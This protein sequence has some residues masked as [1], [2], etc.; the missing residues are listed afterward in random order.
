[1]GQRQRTAKSMGEP[2]FNGST[3][4]IDVSNNTSLNSTTAT[5]SAWFKTTQSA[6]NYPF[7]LGRADGSGSSNGISLFVD[8]SGYARVQ[9]YA[10][11]NTVVDITNH[12]A[13]VNDG[14]WHYLIFTINSST[15]SLYL[16]GSS[17]VVTAIP[18]GSWSFNG[19][20]ARF[21]ISTG[22]FLGQMGRVGR[23]GTC[24][25]R[26]SLGR[27]DATEYNNQSSPSTFYSIGAAVT[28]GGGPGSPVISS[29]SPTLG[30]VGTM[31]TIMGTG[32]GTTQGSNTVT[33]NGTVG[34]TNELERN[35][36][37]NGGADGS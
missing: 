24:F 36:Y 23:R 10:S 32:F 31:T 3:A 28:G 27:L 37:H 7:I 13:A 34:D 12:A 19:Q 25:Q 5:W 15:A 16:D 1:M 26:G 14:N 33:F 9:V 30:P 20:D 4:Y 11:S 22:R 29:L 18:S 35:K 6:S 21:G 2:S 8:P 17:Q